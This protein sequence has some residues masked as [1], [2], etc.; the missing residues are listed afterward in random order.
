MFCILTSL[1]ASDHRLRAVSHFSPRGDFARALACSRA[2]SRALPLDYPRSLSHG[3]IW[4]CSDLYFLPA[5]ITKC[6]P[7]SGNITLI[8]IRVNLLYIEL[9]HKTSFIFVIYSFYL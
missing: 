8:I 2:R 6:F 1:S 5:V 9:F 4:L 3:A 7:L